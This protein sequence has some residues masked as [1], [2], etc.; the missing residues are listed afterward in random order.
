MRRILVCAVALLL[1]LSPQSL[2]GRGRDPLLDEQ[3]GLVLIDAETAWRTARGAGAVIAILDSGVAADHPDLRANVAGRG[4]DAVGGARD[5]ASDTHGTFVAGLAAAVGG[6]GEGIA[7]A[8]PQA[9]ILPVR[10]CRDGCPQEAV[11]DGIRYAARN[12]A[13]V[14]NLSFYVPSLEPETEE[15]LEA[16]AYAR[17]R[18]VVVV[19][20]AGNSAEPWCAQPA[21]SAI[22]VGATDR[23][24]LRTFYS[25]GDAVMQSDFLVAPGG[26]PAENSCSAMIV[27]TVPKAGR[28]PCPAGSRYVYSYGTS[29]AAP[30]VSGVAALLASTGAP[31]D[32]IEECI[33]T[34]ADDLGPQGRDPVFGYGRL[35][36]ASAVACAAGRDV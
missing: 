9:G 31:A 6:N 36:A 14:I 15:V 1:A 8:A 10:V 33:L 13:D 32:T 35:N 25:N 4:Y 30:L 23:W 19:A 2:A 12:G 7:G 27:S 29:A 3:W 16:V 34:S 26:S 21:A 18:G 24:D 17:D 28:H 22:C 11:A 20:A 5:Q